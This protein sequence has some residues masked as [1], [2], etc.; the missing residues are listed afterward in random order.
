MISQ[1][2]DIILMIDRAS[3]LKKRIQICSKFH[4]KVHSKIY[5]KIYPKICPKLKVIKSNLSC[6]TSLKLPI[7]RFNLWMNTLC[8]VL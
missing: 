8:T 2:F 6:P 7:I 3:F 4:T 5:S 1:M